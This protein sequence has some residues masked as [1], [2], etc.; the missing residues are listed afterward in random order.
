MPR[1]DHQGLPGA[2]LEAACRRDASHLCVSLAT[3]SLEQC[4]SS[5]GE[6]REPQSRA[7]AG[8]WGP[9]GAPHPSGRRALAT[10]LRSPKSGQK[11]TPVSGPEG[12]KRTT[13]LGTEPK[14]GTRLKEAESEQE[15]KRERPEHS[16]G[17][18]VGSAGR[19][20]DLQVL[21]GPGR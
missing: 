12:R 4:S 17:G 13:R 11:D 15:G 16:G 5:L 3:E 18:L 14:A 8:L 10:S 7:V 1:H 6:P 19:V 9:A 20:L 2:L 21:T